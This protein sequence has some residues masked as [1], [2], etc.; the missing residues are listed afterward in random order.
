MRTLVGKAAQAAIPS[1]YHMD[2]YHSL[3]PP[4]A[5]AT[6]FVI[7]FGNANLSVSLFSSHCY[8]FFHDMPI[9]GAVVSALSLHHHLFWCIY[10][11]YDFHL[12]T[13]T[14]VVM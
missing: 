11:M 10:L 12:I 6:Q 13:T 4:S 1:L 5:N 7:S 3:P 8:R 9:N 2:C 14:I